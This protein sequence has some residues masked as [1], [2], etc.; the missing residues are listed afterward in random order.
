MQKT[1]DPE[2]LY[3]EDSLNDLS[4]QVLAERNCNKDYVKELKFTDF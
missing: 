3:F 4:L 1:V 2:N